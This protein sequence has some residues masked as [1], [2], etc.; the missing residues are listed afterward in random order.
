M[1]K[2]AEAMGET[3][4]RKNLRSYLKHFGGMTKMIGA[5]ASRTQ[6]ILRCWKLAIK[7]MLFLVLQAQPLMDVLFR[8]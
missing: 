5:H 8:L 7:Q 2:V 4:D 3:F 6:P 1:Q